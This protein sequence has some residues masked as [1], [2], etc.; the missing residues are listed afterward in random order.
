MSS[1]PF[2]RDESVL[3]TSIWREV[4]LQPPPTPRLTPSSTSKSF[5]SRSKDDEE[6]SY[7]LFSEGSDSVS[8]PTPILTFHRIGGSKKP[9]SDEILFSGGGCRLAH[10]ISEPTSSLAYRPDIDLRSIMRVEEACTRPLDEAKRIDE[11]SSVSTFTQWTNGVNRHFVDNG[12][13][14]IAHVLKPKMKGAS[15]RDINN[16]KDVEKTCALCGS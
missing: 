7:I 10:R 1:E 14:S 5:L 6:K 3:Y 8:T 15:L 16:I 2:P 11:C 12:L 13:D 9:G 4:D